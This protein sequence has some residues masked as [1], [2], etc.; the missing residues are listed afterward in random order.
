M[1]PGATVPQCAATHQGHADNHGCGAR[2][3]LLQPPNGTGPAAQLRS[4]PGAEEPDPARYSEEVRQVARTYRQELWCRPRAP[5]GPVEL[6]LYRGYVVPG[7]M[8]L[9]FPPHGDV[10]HSLCDAGG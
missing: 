6:P 9:R 1:G 4:F 5:A 8:D 2:Q 7:S 10:H 3:V